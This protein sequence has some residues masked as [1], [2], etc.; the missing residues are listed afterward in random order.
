MQPHQI[1]APKR[2]EAEVLHRAMRAGRNRALLI[3]A[4]GDD[5]ELIDCVAKLPGLM[6]NGA[7]HPLPSLLEWLGA[8][9][10]AELGVTSPKPYEVIIAREFAEG[11]RDEVI[12]AGV[13]KSIGSV[14]GSGFVRGAPMVAGDLV[15][16]SMRTDATTV[17]AFDTFIH[18]LDRRADNPNLFLG[19]TELIAFDHGDAFAFVFPM[20][21]APDPVT[22]P[23]L[24]ILAKHALASCV[25]RRGEPDLSEFRT[26]LLA[27]DDARLE[28]ISAA[29]PAAWQIGMAQGKLQDVL[30]ILRR[31]RDAV[32][33]WLPQVE[34]W[35]QG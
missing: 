4:R 18:N 14:F 30:D 11:I 19:R 17:I 23:L 25:R 9:L 24:S 3:G 31:R 32:D 27:L 34:A 29:T 2:L 22:D 35:M 13:A 8:A 15:E 21:G 10:A 1:A 6:E 33:Q 5:G 26:R 12:R 16:P 20:I 7:M 28:Q